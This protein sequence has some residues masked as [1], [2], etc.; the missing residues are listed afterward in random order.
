MVLKEIKSE[1]DSKSSTDGGRTYNVRPLKDEFVED[2]IYTPGDE[3]LVKTVL[4]KDENSYYKGQLYV[5]IK[6]PNSSYYRTDYCLWDEKYQLENDYYW[7][8]WH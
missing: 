4:K 3:T 2:S 6:S 1:V 8:W 5:S 7:V